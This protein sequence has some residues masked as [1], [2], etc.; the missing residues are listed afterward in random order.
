MGLFNSVLLAGAFQGIVLSV[1][2]FSRKQNRLPNTLLAALTI[3]F[4]LQILLVANDNRDFFLSFPHLS[5]IGWLIPTLFGPLFFL[6]VCTLTQEGQKWKN[7]Y[8]LHF[9]PFAVYLL[10]LLPYYLQS[11]EEKRA[12]LDQYEL[13]SKNDFGLSNQ[14]L[15]LLHVS[16][17]TA[18]VIF[19]QRHA[20]RVEEVFSETS[21]LKLVWLK[22]LNQW[23]LGILI[24]G[25]A[26][27]YAKK[28]DWTALSWLYP[29]HYLG[30]VAL[31][32]WIGYKSLAQQEIFLREPAASQPAQTNYTYEAFLPEEPQ[33]PGPSA[34]EAK[35]VRSN[36][37]EEQACRCAEQLLEYMNEAKPYLSDSLSIYELA[38]ALQISKHHLSQL[39]NGRFQKNFYD[40]VN[41]YRVE[42]VKKLMRDPKK[43]HLNTLALALEAGFK[44]KATF[45]AS[46]KKLTGQTP[47]EY[48]KKGEIVA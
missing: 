44:S 24:L 13:A 33:E 16:Y 29:Y 34:A 11:A 1:L 38:H 21:Q 17:L 46:F 25:V 32:Y 4:S 8:Y 47:T 31:I 41:T 27:F 30:V 26:V 28:F 18:S 12:I 40:F 36:F 22:N 5:R 37:T 7:R 15:N 9:L 45:N 48:Q 6:F 3:V 35:Y 23:V 39:I 42:E 10:L 19:L 20:Q 43:Q 2:L 14:L